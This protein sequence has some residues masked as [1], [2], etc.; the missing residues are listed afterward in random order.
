[1][2]RK[3]IFLALILAITLGLTSCFLG[4]LEGDTDTQSSTE[5]VPEEEMGDYIVTFDTQGGSY[6]PPQR[7]NKNNKIYEPQIPTKEGNTFDGWYKGT[8]KWDFKLQVATED[9]TLVAKWIPDINTVLVESEVDGVK[10]NYFTVGGGTF[11]YGEETECW[12]QPR[13][14]YTF[15]GWYEGDTL[16]TSDYKFTDTIK[17]ERHFIAK[18]SKNNIIFIADYYGEFNATILVDGAEAELY[19]NENATK[20]LGD[21]MTVSAIVRDGYVF[22]GWYKDGEL[23]SSENKI[24][25]EFNGKSQEYSLKLKEDPVLDLFEFDNSTSFG[26]RITGIKDKTLTEIYVPDIVDTIWEGAFEGCS[27]LESISLPFIGCDRYRGGSVVPCFGHLF[28]AFEFENTTY[29]IQY[30]ESYIPDKTSEYYIPNS[31]KEVHL[32]NGSIPMG[33]FS[34]CTM[35]EEIYFE[36]GLNEIPEKAFYSCTGLKTIY[37][38]GTE[39]EWNLLEKGELW[40]HNTTFEVVFL[41][42]E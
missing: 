17:K 20:E 34:N 7:T 22:D 36:E 24:T 35:I 33:A 30:N 25:V 37:Y 12:V 15:L 39:A 8:W 6:I 21:T 42:E 18:W 32:R 11:E 10:D 5:S 41:K 1:M 31:I 38:N 4:E 3:I 19:Y 40:D 23:I 14:G 2:K 13:Q 28:G 26:C 9:T 27:N 29:V 16:V